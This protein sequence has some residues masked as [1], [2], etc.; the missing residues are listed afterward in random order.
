MRTV[1][2]RI[3]PLLLALLL[4]AG[5][6]YP[7]RDPE[8]NESSSVDLL[9]M[10]TVMRVTAYGKHR[11]A[12]ELA[13]E[14]IT[15]LEAL[16]SVTNESSE[17]YAANHAQGAPVE[18]S[19]DT[20]A[21]LSRALELCDSTGGVL[22]VTIYPVV[23]A[24][25]FTTDR[26]RVPG[27]EELSALLERVDYKQVALD[28]NTLT[29]PEGVELDLGAVAKGYTGDCVAALLRGE[30][31][32]SALLELGGNIQAVGSKP[33]GSPWRV[34]V[35][36]PNGGGFAGVVEIVNKAVVTSGGYERYFEQDGETYWHI[37]DPATGRPARSGLLSVTIIAEE[38]VKCDALSTA[39]FV[40][41]P[42]K[43]ADYWREN[44]GFDCILLSD[45]GRIILTEGIEDSFTPY[46]DWTDAPV[47]VITR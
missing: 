4:L 37:I 14:K 32:E 1:R 39:L 9:A 47:E 29:L 36:D 8:A 2:R 44:G 46:G 24:W 25:G 43:A 28:G 5:C 45:D 40:M 6:A 26:F 27:A 23:R 21:L 34:A 35:T 10:D 12:A 30:G 3:I 18:L 17:I 16:L 42:E 15:A 41:G 11:E 7:A 19:P 22:D 33:G 31:V 38:G 20:A 13:R